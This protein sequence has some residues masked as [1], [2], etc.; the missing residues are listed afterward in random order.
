MWPVPNDFLGELFPG[1]F[2]VSSEEELI[3][4]DHLHSPPFTFSDQTNLA[5]FFFFSL[6][7]KSLADTK[8][9]LAFNI[10]NNLLFI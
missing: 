8:I 10:F 6:E 2:P 5:F 1:C 9:L 4:P 7:F 3:Q